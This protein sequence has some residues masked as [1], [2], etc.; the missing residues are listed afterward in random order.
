M[1]NH[2]N[3]TVQYSITPRYNNDLDITQSCCGS[4]FFY[5]NLDFYKVIIIGDCHFP[6]ISL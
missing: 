2:C 4:D 6:V 3:Y 1:T 5:Y